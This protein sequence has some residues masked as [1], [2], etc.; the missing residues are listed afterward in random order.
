[1][2]KVPD[3]EKEK[4]GY[5][6]EA[7]ADQSINRPNQQ[8]EKKRLSRIPHIPPNAKCQDSDGYF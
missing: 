7:D 1:M 2:K 5:N 4:F 3:Q 6:K 8:C